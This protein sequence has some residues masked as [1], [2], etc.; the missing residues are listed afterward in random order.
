MS[1]RRVES[2]GDS[3]VRLYQ[4][5]NSR[6]YVMTV[7][8]QV[9]DACNLACSYCYQINKNTHVMPVEIGK[10]FL[11]IILTRSKG[12]NEYCPYPLDGLIVEFIGGEPFLA[13]DLIEELTDYLI[14]RMVELN[15]PLLNKFKIS[16]CSNGVLYFTPKVQAYLRKHLNHLSFG[17]SIDGNKELHDT[18][19]VFPDG[20][21]SYDIAIAG[22]KHFT[23]VLGGYMGSK[24][25]LAPENVRYTFDAVKNLIDLGYNEINLNCVFEEGWTLEH[26]KILYSQL[27]QVADYLVDNNLD[28]QIYLSIFNQRLF[29]PINSLSNENWCGGT[30]KMLAVDWKGDIYPCLRYMESSIGTQVKPL[31]VGNVKDGIFITNEQRDCIKCLQ[32]ITR[33]SQS[34]DECFYCPIAEGCAWC[35]AY[36]YQCFG[37]ADKRATYICIMHK[38][39]ALANAYY[40]NKKFR[41]EHSNKRMKLWIPEDWAL[42]IIDQDEWDMLKQMEGA[43]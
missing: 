40:W 32:S 13:I 23:E 31:I 26:A 14:D 39:R 1:N 42:E 35:S 24:M 7:T 4:K 29:R 22:V 33:R 10:E 28:D 38:A 34:T 3:L 30:G 12:F 18:C 43:E 41:K 11:D 6:F 27:K 2:F 15:H 21:G 36:N 8:I 19:R 16:I 25:T 9:T 5:P 37:T 17:I 20:S